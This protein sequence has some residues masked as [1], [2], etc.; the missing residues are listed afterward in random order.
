VGTRELLGQ[1]IDV[2]EVPVGFVFVL[3]LQLV[4]VEALVVKLGRVAIG[5]VS[6]D[7]GG[8]LD[9]GLLLQGKCRRQLDCRGRDTMV[10]KDKARL[11]RLQNG[12]ERGTYP[13]P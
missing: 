11:D 1:A 4:A 10:S 12:I 7:L 3:L 2:V 13:C 5:G 6:A 8:R 9:D